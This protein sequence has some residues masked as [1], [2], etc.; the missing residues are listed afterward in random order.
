MARERMIVSHNLKLKSDG[1]AVYASIKAEWHGLGENTN[2][3]K[4]DVDDALAKTGMDDYDL[5]EQPLTDP[6]GPVPTHKSI[7]CVSRSNPDDRPVVGVT[8]INRP[9]FQPRVMLEPLNA[10]TGDGRSVI[11]AGM[12]GNGG[13]W[14]GVVEFPQ[15]W[16]ICGRD[17]RG[18]LF[19]R[20][21]ADGSS[22]LDIRPTAICVVCQNT[23]NMAVAD[24]SMPRFVLRH[25]SNA[26]ARLS[27]QAVRDVIG[28]VPAYMDDLKGEMEALYL[29]D[30][31]YQQFRALTDDLFGTPNPDAKSTRS[32]TIYGN[33]LAELNRLW[34]SDTQAASYRMGKPTALTAFDAIGEYLDHT[35]GSDKGRLDR[36]VMGDTARIK[37]RALVA[38][39]A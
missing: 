28:M 29:K 6:M 12:L 11:S 31:T 39:T 24:K 5:V 17:Y 10:L 3:V 35:Y 34:K 18:Y 13:V 37:A 25:T 38:L 36:Q 26:Q 30:A 14:F 1:T 20:D 16:T 2:G 21:S 4:M 15:G 7:R 32:Q 9:V 23:Y 19:G 33:R 8:G 22:A 27:A